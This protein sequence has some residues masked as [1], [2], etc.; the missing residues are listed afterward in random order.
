MYRRP[1]YREAIQVRRTI[2]NIG[3]IP[4]IFIQAIA[5]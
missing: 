1:I 3:L 4:L 2:A 5:L